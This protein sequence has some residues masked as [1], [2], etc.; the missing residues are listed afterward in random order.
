MSRAS[1][2]DPDAPES[3]AGGEDVPGAFLS[4]PQI[5]GVRT[6]IVIYAATVL[7]LTAGN[8]RPLGNA[9]FRLSS[10]HLAIRLSIGLM[11][12]TTALTFFLL[13]GMSL[14]HYFQGHAKPRPAPGWLWV[15]VLLNVVGVVV[16]YLKIIEPE[17]RSLLERTNPRGDSPG[18]KP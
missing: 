13:L 16:Y 4:R 17:Q 9:L 14:H 1:L 11:V 2:F 7:L 5:L 8:Y 3:P 18:E 10:M 6:L 15:I 12:S